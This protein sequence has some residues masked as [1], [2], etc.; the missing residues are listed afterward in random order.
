MA[1]IPEYALAA[2]RPE[3]LHEADD[4][5][6][7]W[8]TSSEPEAG[9]EASYFAP[10]ARRFEPLPEHERRE[11]S[12]ARTLARRAGRAAKRSQP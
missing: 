5:S 6:H 10:F 2:L 4:L 3:A 8:D 9:L 1:S 12:K 11:A 7:A